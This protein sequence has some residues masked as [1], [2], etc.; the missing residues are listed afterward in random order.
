MN[1][2]EKL[3]FFACIVFPQTYFE[4]VGIDWLEP[5]ANGGAEPNR[6]TTEVLPGGERR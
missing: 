3:I 2:N 4:T 5:N 6:K 1:N